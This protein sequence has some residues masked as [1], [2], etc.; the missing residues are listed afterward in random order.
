MK[1]ITIGRRS[2]FLGAVAAAVSSALP[3]TAA[4]A[5]GGSS[6][7]HVSFAT[8]GHI[9]EVI[10]NPYSI[11]PLT[12]IIRNGGYELT[13]ATVRIVPKPQGQE[14]KYKVSRSEL[15]THAG[16]PVFGLYPDYMNTVE[17]TYTR[18]FH[19]KTEKFTDTY[20]IYAA[21]V[22]HE[23]SGSPG[24]HHN[25]FETKVTKV[26]AKFSDRLY[27]VNNLMQQYA[28]ATRAVWN[29][30]MGGAMEWNF[31]PQNAIIDTKGEVRW[32]MHVEP[33][34][35]VETIYHSGVMMGFQQDEDGNLTWGLANGVFG[36]AAAAA[37]Q[38]K[39]DV[40]TTTNALAIAASL[41]SGIRANFGSQTKA[42][43]AGLSNLH[44]M[45]AVEL[46]AAG[47]TGKDDALEASDGY[48]ACFAARLPREKCTVD[49]GSRWDLM[50]NG[51][52]FKQYPCCSGTHPA[53][54]VW[55]EW[56]D[57]VHPKLDDIEAVHLGVSL[58]G[59]LELISHCPRNA[60]EAKFSMEFALA[61]RLVYQRTGI[62]EFTDD[63]VLDVRIQALMKKM[64]MEIDPDLAKLGFIGTAPVRI[65]I[66]TKSGVV[67]L[68][69]DLAKGNPEKPLSESDRKAK[70]S[71]C[72]S[73]IA[74]SETAARWWNELSTLELLSPNQLSLLGAL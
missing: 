73:P 52:V 29:N 2:F 53:L 50:E 18:K 1:N 63:K 28:K 5:S 33:I 62:E 30:P 22:Y 36:A 40:S 17:T 20:K 19:G 67:C 58:L 69:N 35:N 71:S 41:A 32:Y 57:K 8:Q 48:A 60:V 49:L 37:W 38:L 55:G 61:S 66:K 16:I 54:D 45:M 64:T 42:I 6:G 25:M 15:L 9:G 34:Y 14:I 59:P 47:I 65:R 27:L 4:H 44:G 56:V 31:Y 10:V 51:L 72:V 39:T 46:A 23:V 68:A 3:A 24:L 12:A 7:P 11:A 21:P 26:D 74:G 13:E 43:H 70:F